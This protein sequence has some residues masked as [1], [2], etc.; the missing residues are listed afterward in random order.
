MDK[1]RICSWQ[2]GS[3]D[4]QTSSAS[5]SYLLNAQY[6]GFE[7][8]NPSAPSLLSYAFDIES[9]HFVERWIDP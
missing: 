5:R 7:P 8:K 1:I 6:K 9:I 3:L 2:F 4:S